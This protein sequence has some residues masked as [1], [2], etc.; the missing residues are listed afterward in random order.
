MRTIQASLLMDGGPAD[1]D[2]AV[3][4]LSALRKRITELESRAEPLQRT[5]VA[6]MKRAGYASFTTT[7]GT[8]A[9]LDPNGANITFEIE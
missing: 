3:E 7:A 4:E 9:R 2:L 6:T 5:V 8:T 1:L